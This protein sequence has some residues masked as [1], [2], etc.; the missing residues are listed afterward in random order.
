MK[1]WKRFGAMLLLCVICCGLLPVSVKADSADTSFY[2][3]ASVASAY[4]S[5]A[6]AEDNGSVLSTIDLDSTTVGAFLGYSDEADSAG[7]VSGWIASALSGSSVTYSYSSLYKLKVSADAESDDASTNSLA[8]W[9]YAQYGRILNQLGLDK[10]GSESSFKFV[11][12]VSGGALRLAYYGVSSV[13]GLLDGI[14]GVLDTLNPFRLIKPNSRTLQSLDYTVDDSDSPLHG[15]GEIMTNLY[16]FFSDRIVIGV[17]LG[18][19]VAVFLAGI[20]L[21]AA[22]LSSEKSST[23]ASFK[24]LLIRAFALVLGIPVLA[25][26]YTEALGLLTGGNGALF[27]SPSDAAAISVVEILSD[28]EN[29]ASKGY[30]GLSSISGTDIVLEGN[31]SS[32]VNYNATMALRYVTPTA[33]TYINLPKTTKA[34]NYKWGLYGA[35]VN[36]GNEDSNQSTIGDYALNLINR[37]SDS[38][39]YTASD[40]E[41]YHK[42]RMTYSTFESI[43]QKCCSVDAFKTNVADLFGTGY[44]ANQIWKSSTSAGLTSS[45][46][47]TYNDGSTITFMDAGGSP[48]FCA[49]KLSPMSVYNYLNSRF[50]ATSVVV[51][52]AEKASSGYV[53]DSH[54]SVSLIGNGFS[55][56]M[57]WLNTLITLF[58]TALLGWVWCFGLLVNAVKRTVRMCMALPGAMLG[59]LKSVANLLIYTIM[60]VVEIVL[61]A[62]LFQVGSAMLNAASG[63]VSDWAGGV[64]Q[65]LNNTLNPPAGG[66]TILQGATVATFGGEALVIVSQVVS[67]IGMLLV[68]ILL[69]KMR[70]GIIKSV[71][72]GL[73]GIVNRLV[74]TNASGMG[75]SDDGRL[76]GALGAGAG[77]A[78]AAKLGSGSDKDKDSKRIEGGSSGGQGQVGSGDKDKPELSSGDEAPG[79]TSGDSAGSGD[80]GDTVNISDDDTATASFDDNGEDEAASMEAGDSLSSLNDGTSEVDSERMDGADGQSLE[81][82]RDETGGEQPDTPEAEL[83]ENGAESVEDVQQDAQETASELADGDNG[84]REPDDHDGGKPGESKSGSNAEQTGKQSGKQPENKNGVKQDANKP[85]ETKSGEKGTDGKPVDGKLGTDSN[86]KKQADVKSTSQSGQQQSKTQG[87]SQDVK[88]GET[89]SSDK[90]KTAGDKTGGNQSTGEKLSAGDKPGMVG[91]KKPSV[92]DGGASTNLSEAMMRNQNAQ[93]KLAALQAEVGANNGSNVGAA[94]A[95]TPG[96]S[97]DSEQ[98]VSGV[99]GNA[100]KVDASGNPVVDK[101]QP[102]GLSGQDSEKKPG[103]QGVGAART[104]SDTSDTAGLHPEQ[105]NGQVSG[106]VGAGQKPLDNPRDTHQQEQTASPITSVDG[107]QRGGQ[108][109]GGVG[110]AHER[111]QGADGSV[112]GGH[113]TGSGAIHQDVSGGQV[114]GQKVVGADGQTHGQMHQDGQQDGHIGDKRVSGDGA[115]TQGQ[116]SGNLSGEQSGQ[117]GVKSGSERMG[118][119]APIGASSMGRQDGTVGERQGSIEAQ[120]SRDTAVA[121]KANEEH[122][123][124]DGSKVSARGAAVAAEREQSSLRASGDGVEMQHQKEAQHA[125]RVESQVVSADGEISS[126]GSIE[127]RGMSKE[128][129]SVTL[130]PGDDSTYVTKDGN[131]AVQITRGGQPAPSVEGG[132]VTERRSSEMSETVQTTKTTTRSGGQQGGKT[133]VAGIAAQAAVAA[134]MASSDN[135]FVRGAGYAGM[136]GVSRQLQDVPQRESRGDGF[137]ETEV[138]TTTVTRHGAE[139]YER[140]QS[141]ADYQ[142]S[143]RQQIENLDSDTAAI[144]AQIRELERQKAAMPKVQSRKLN[145]NTPGSEE[146]L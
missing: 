143:V 112:A 11:R 12:S 56:F 1:R 87:Q 15:L 25:V 126:Q 41:T 100:G 97:G 92:P 93:A 73:T 59:S 84:M 26:C 51:Y 47:T 133:P 118:P 3:L 139:S 28:F 68:C 91:E 43:L 2:K 85:G 48:G 123:Y 110:A 69:V 40:F 79:L 7:G 6:L 63:I 88:P 130:K 16:A 108:T 90:A 86:G 61:T 17:I 19:W 95:N 58:A 119:S 53:R 107:E 77:A 127:T 38:A 142:E 52:S 80:A 135:K 128:Q 44:S 33:N 129:S 89:K 20:L 104:A 30:L 29:W 124:A 103:T 117:P 57:Y 122:Q 125:S 138:E 72:E 106:S 109:P 102:A 34:I 111:Q 50:D 24:R 116:V 145:D 54:Y 134:F 136:M 67:V 120:H 65:A 21:P 105:N 32:S 101:A 75:Y 14:V 39:F 140:E 64:S 31:V 46:A 81:D 8:F 45:M 62:F 83:A 18:L 131:N 76:A 113:Q 99:S 49:G 98:Q 144:E 70:K 36:T 114:G 132:S 66:V 13:G 42:T 82:L 9:E 96:K 146:Y 121:A 4:F 23:F 55:S 60:G 94:K 27:E 22:G 78:M 10:T 115:Q 74:G 35:S 37:Y 141:A 137:V 5:N 71:D